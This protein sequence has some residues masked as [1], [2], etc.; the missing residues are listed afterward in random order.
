M[1]DPYVAVAI[2]S[3]VAA[4]FD[5]H[6]AIQRNLA[7]AEYLID[8]VVAAVKMSAG[9]RGP[10]LIVF[11]EAFLTGFGPVNTRTYQQN[12]DMSVYVPGK[13]IEVLA[14]K[15]RE[16]NLYIA[17]TIFER[18]DEYPCHFFNLGFLLNSDGELA[19]KYRKHMVAHG[20]ELATTPADVLGKMGMDPKVLFPVADTELGRLG[21]FICNDRRFPEVARS[22]ALMGAEI[23]IHPTGAGSVQAG[24]KKMLESWRMI[25]Q[26]RAFENNAYL[27][28]AQWAH[29]PESE[30]FTSV[31]HSLIIDFNGDIMSEIDGIQEGFVMATI[32]PEALRRKRAGGGFLLEVQSPIYAEVYNQ[33]KMWPVDPNG[34]AETLP[35]DLEERRAVRAEVY[36]QRVEEGV[37]KAP[38]E[39]VPVKS[40]R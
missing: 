27:I 7:N 8:R 6:G 14:D 25:T 4:A 23:L 24:A 31:A 1:L 40:D 15:A 13:E 26:V 30:L 5:D 3:N 21:L 18:D 36:R 10:K 29:S 17:G 32:D 19:L 22:L 16:H 33:A 12:Y 9:G 11:P 38:A 20:V 37:F 39:Q 28:G 35:A 34:Y 2:Q